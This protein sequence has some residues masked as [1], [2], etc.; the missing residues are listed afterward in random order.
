MLT[1]S[2]LIFRCTALVF[3]FHFFFFNFYFRWITI[4]HPRW[5]CFSFLTGDLNNI[6]IPIKWF[7]KISSRVLHQSW[8]TKKNVPSYIPCRF[9]YCVYFEILFSSCYCLWH[10]TTDFES[11]N[12]HSF[13]HSDTVKNTITKK[14]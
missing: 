4:C 9:F 13:V 2:T 5:Q 10:A 8:A 6:V 3:I 1:F 7:H 14:K 11:I 12:F